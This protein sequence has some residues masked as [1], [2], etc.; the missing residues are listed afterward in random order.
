MLQGNHT[1]I[2]SEPSKHVGKY[3]VNDNLHIYFKTK[4]SLVN[5]LFT[6]LLLGW[7]WVDIEESN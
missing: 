1:F 6:R 4:P 7:K 3:V 5:R 2:L